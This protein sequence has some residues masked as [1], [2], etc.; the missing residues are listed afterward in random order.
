MTWI[1]EFYISGK[2]PWGILPIACPNCHNPIK[3]GEEVLSFGYYRH[4]SCHKEI[5]QTRNQLGVRSG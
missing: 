2:T 4:K 1:K 5:I 3:L